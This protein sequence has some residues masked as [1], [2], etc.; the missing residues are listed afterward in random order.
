M[1][2]SATTQMGIFR[3]NPDGARLSGRSALSLAL[4]MCTRHSTR[5]ASRI[6]SRKAG[7]AATRDS[8]RDS[9]C[10]DELLPRQ[11]REQ[12]GEA[13]VAGNALEFDAAPVLVYE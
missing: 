1:P 10:P 12:E 9:L 11:Q 8:F 13:G 7:A 2:R 6:S 4:R 3:A 5:L